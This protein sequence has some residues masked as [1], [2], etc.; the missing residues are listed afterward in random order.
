MRGIIQK[1]K[2]GLQVCSEFGVESFFKRL[3]NKKYHRIPDLETVRNAHLTGEEELERQRMVTF[4]HPVKFSI[5]TPLYNT[6]EQFLKELLESLKNQT[7]G[8]WELC[9]ADGSD[10]EHAYVGE[11][12]R[13]WAE[14]EERI[15]YHVLSENKGI[16]ENTNQCI[17]LATGDYFGLLDHDDVLHPSALFEA[18]KAIEEQGAEFLYTD[19][20]KFSG[21]VSDISDPRMFNLK[22][23]FGK[24]DLRSHNYI[25]HFTVFSRK[26]LEGEERFYRKECDG[27]QDHDMV[28]RLTEKTDAIV[29][30]PKVLYYWRVHENS[31]S[32]NLEG[33]IYAVDSAIRAIDEQLIRTG[34]AGK[35][36]SN[37]PFQTIYR[38][39]YEMKG[40]PL[41]SIVLH[42]TEKEKISM[43]VNNIRKCTSYQNLEFV[44]F[45]EKNPDL[46]SGNIRQKCIKPDEGLSRAEKWNQAVKSASGEY[47]VFL[48]KDCR[49]LSENWI[50]ELLM[51]AQREDVCTAGPK[52]YYHDDTIAYA[53][54]ALW[55]ENR[56]GLELLCAHDT[57]ADIG[58]EGLLC[59]VRETTAA[60]ASCMMFSRK[61]WKDRGGFRNACPGYEDID[62]CLRGQKAGLNNV[63]T[64]FAEM[65]FMGR[66]FVTPKSNVQAETFKSTWKESFSKEQYCH[67][68]WKKLRIV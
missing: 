2:N 52:V 37:L 22:P 61:S 6:P 20:V 8:N 41:V 50:Q 34:E 45:S 54:I 7:Y 11:I 58:Y 16:S 47:L 29:H 27:S 51:F 17:Q 9:L 24:D 21:A 49:P 35:A 5:I 40:E 31:V 67:R 68:L 42:N 38:I 13:A 59:H 56:D 44:F 19:E 14:K 46:G 30:I 66:H 15:R 62:F 33:K 63:W 26:L 64:C 12:C 55:Q 3:D 10:S 28:L 32:Q 65:R 57:R 48:D 36:A 25:C 43:A 53:G 39:T 23:G 1:A 60:S 4:E 18:M